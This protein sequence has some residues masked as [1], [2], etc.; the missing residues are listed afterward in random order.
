MSKRRIRKTGDGWSQ[1]K[2]TPEQLKEIR[3]ALKKLSKKSRAKRVSKNKNKKAISFKQSNADDAMT[4][5][6]KTSN[7]LKTMFDQS[8]K[9]T[10]M[11]AT[12]YSKGVK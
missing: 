9:R 6:S 5:S 2:H 7:R 10:T 12:K 4:S 1:D 11:N 8:T 3:D